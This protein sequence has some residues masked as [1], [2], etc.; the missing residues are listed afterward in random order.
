[1]KGPIPRARLRGLPLRLR[2]LRRLRLTLLGGS[3]LQPPLPL[4][5][6]HPK[7]VA[8]DK[9][10]RFVRGG[11]QPLYLVVRTVEISM[12]ATDRRRDKRSTYSSD[13]QWR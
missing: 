12:G 10:R 9:K 13:L 4:V 3:L 11:G 1:M 8:V 6:H 7:L 2:R 5:F